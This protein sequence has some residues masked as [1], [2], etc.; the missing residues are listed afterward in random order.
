[1]EIDY[2]IGLEIKDKVIPYA[3]HWYTGEAALLFD[4]DYDVE[5]ELYGYEEEG[6]ESGE[7]GSEGEPAAAGRG[8]GRFEDSPPAG[9]GR[10][11]GRGAKPAP[12]TAQSS[13]TPTPNAPP[14]S[15][16]THECDKMKSEDFAVLTPGAC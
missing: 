12:V 13:S 8:R 16:L 3:I 2:D 14:P 1:M 10:G 11:R 7:S 6:G 15:A 5:D 4:D 9:R